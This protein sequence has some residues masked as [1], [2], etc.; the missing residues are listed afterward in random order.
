MEANMTQPPPSYSQMKWEKKCFN[1]VKK[2][3]VGD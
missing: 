2:N 3:G 1:A